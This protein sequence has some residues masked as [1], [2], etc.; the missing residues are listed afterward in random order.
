MGEGPT[1]AEILD[2]MR[3]HAPEH[4]VAGL[5]LAGELA[6]AY[7]VMHHAL[8]ASAWD[9]LDRLA[10]VVQAEVDAARRE[11]EQGPREG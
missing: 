9:R 7:G 1:D 6:D 5:V 11:R 3:E 10:D 4:M 8:G 2:W